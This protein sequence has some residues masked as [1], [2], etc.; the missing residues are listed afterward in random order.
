[1]LRNRSL[2]FLIAGHLNFVRNKRHTT[3]QFADRS[4]DHDEL[5]ACEQPRGKTEGAT[6]FPIWRTLL[7][8]GRDP[9]FGFG[10]LARFHVM[11][12]R[13]FDILFD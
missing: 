5:I 12:Q 2:S 3:I 1:M 11:S 13:S 10:R 8:K 6:L 4:D 7:E 9:F